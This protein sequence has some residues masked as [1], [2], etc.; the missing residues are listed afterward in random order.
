[1]SGIKNPSQPYVNIDHFRR[2]PLAPE[3]PSVAPHASESGK[4]RGSLERGDGWMCVVRTAQADPR[5]WGG[6]RWELR[7]RGTPASLST[8]TGG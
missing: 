4:Q 5:I 8:A 2:A 7:S 3:Q 1:M 6:G